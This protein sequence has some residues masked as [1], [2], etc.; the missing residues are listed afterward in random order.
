MLKEEACKQFYK[1]YL[2][3]SDKEK[4]DFAEMANRLLQVN[5]I[6]GKKNREVLR[7]YKDKAQIF[8]NYFFMIDLEFGISA[9]LQVAYLK[10]INNFNR[11][12]LN[13][14]ESL[15]LLILRKLYQTE[16]EKI[17]LSGEVSINLSDLNTKLAELNNNKENKFNKGEIKTI[18]K[19]FRDYNIVDYLN[20]DFEYDPRII[21]NSAIMIAVSY[22]NMKDIV[23]KIESY[24]KVKDDEETDEN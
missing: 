15:V 10:N 11:L 16:F 1:L 12:S 7:F 9:E 18:L 6:S 20:F 23:S 21:I 5:F 3:F 4:E 2:E 14:N 8:A 24:S 22:E 19:K 13:K 17:T